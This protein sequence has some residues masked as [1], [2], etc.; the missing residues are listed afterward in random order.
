MVGL[1]CLCGLFT[2]CGDDEK[3]LVGPSNENAR[4]VSPTIS[5][6]IEEPGGLSPL[7]GVLQAYP[8]ESESSTFFGNYVNGTLRPF[9]A[10]YLVSEGHVSG[11]ISNALSLPAGYYNMVYWATPRHDEP[12]DD[13]PE[14]HEPGLSPGVDLST[15]YFSLREN[16]E[17]DTYKPVYD[18]AHAVHETHTTSDFQASLRRVVA[19]LNVKVVRE[20]NGA[21]DA[22]TSMRVR[23][24][25]IAEKLNLYTGEPENQ[26]KTVRFDLVRSTDGTSMSNATVMLFPSAANPK[27]ELLITRADGTT[28]TL[29]RNLN[30]TL[31]PNTRLSLN[32]VIKERYPGSVTGNFTIQNWTEAQ[33]TIEFE[34]DNL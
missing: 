9:V 23:I 18:M 13:A 14:I 20:D 3:T 24:G 19:G 6:R 30:S 2:A 31:S 12:I 7:T 34:V 32:I 16:T 33:E 10:S 25:G 26:T 11:V 15:L 1:A 17:D 21:F 28:E 29:S 5:A 4:L 22:A 27:L 8:C